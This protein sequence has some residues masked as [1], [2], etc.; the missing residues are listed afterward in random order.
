MLYGG[1]FESLDQ[2][3]QFG[4]QHFDELSPGFVP[5]VEL[6]GRQP[7]HGQYSLRLAM[8]SERAAMATPGEGASRI[9]VVSPPLYVEPRQIVEIT[10]WTR[11]SSDPSAASGLV[12]SDSFGGAELALCVAPS[13][14]WRPFRIIRTATSNELRISLDFAGAG[15]AQ[16]LTH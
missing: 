3:A 12:I 5:H 11:V 9:R 6:D 15:S 16:T 2:L 14:D 8:G 13:P 4:W 10:G 7:F 1:D